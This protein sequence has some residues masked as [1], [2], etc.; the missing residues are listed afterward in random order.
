MRNNTGGARNAAFGHFVL[1]NNSTGGNNSAFGHFALYSNTTGAD[2][3]AL[4]RYA[5]KQN[6]TG[7]RN[8]AI[9]IAAGQSQTTGNDN[10]YIG[11]N[12]LPG[13][14][15]QIRIGDFGVHTQA[16]IAGI[17]GSTSANGVPV[18]VNG[19][20]TLG[21]TTSS[22]RFKQDVHDLGDASDLLM[23]LRPVRFHYLEEAV[24][25]E[26][27]KTPQYGLIAEEVAEVAPELV[28]QDA[29]GAPYSVKYHVLP[30]LLVAEAQKQR[31]TAASQE[32]RLAEQSA[33]IAAQRQEIASLASRLARLEA[34]REVAGATEAR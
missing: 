1:P 9:G 18:L 12:A 16:H 25:P 17:V 10:I 7:S 3:T 31:S 13:E 14:S 21:T 29:E 30:A 4:G 26:D 15:G 34:A 11:S 8:I 5:L 22:A 28:V 24:G 32:R 2:N 33:V 6:T 23:R 27:A 19:V 20:G